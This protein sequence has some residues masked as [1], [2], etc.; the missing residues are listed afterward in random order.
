[1]EETASTISDPIKNHQEHEENRAEEIDPII[2]ESAS[3]VGEIAIKE[4]TV[5]QQ[6]NELTLDQKEMQI[7]TRETNEISQEVD[8]NSLED[9]TQNLSSKTEEN[10]DQIFKYN[11]SIS[12]I[13]LCSATE[14]YEPNA[15]CENFTKGCLWSPD[16]TCLL[17]PA[18]DFRLRVYELPTILYSGKFPQDSLSSLKPVFSIKEGGI[19]YDCS[20]YPLMNSW[21]PETCC[22]ISTSKETPIHLWDAF[23]GQLRATYRAYNQVDEVEAAISVQF[24]DHGQTVWAG[25]KGALRSFDTN[26]PGRQIE[27]IFLKHDF[28]NV[29][30]I[31]SCI[32]ENPKM[33]GL[34]AFGT[35][36]KCIGLYNNGPLCS[37]KASSGVTQVE[38]SPCGTKLYAAVRRNDEFV[39]WDLRNP[40]IILYSLEGRRS[41]TN[42][43]IQFS[44]SPDGN[45]VI[46]GGTNG[47]VNVWKTSEINCS[48]I[49]P[50]WRISL[51]GDC[52]NG[53]NVHKCL[54]IMAT[55]SGQRLCEED[56]VI[57]DNSV[58]LWYCG[59]GID[60]S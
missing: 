24:S 49:Q 42:Q 60:K 58:R 27:D 57:R 38:F 9:D 53:V 48:E 10:E 13:L 50:S 12:P 19:V 8:K 21:Q 2:P 14:E 17:V 26:R 39:C 28:P 55:S 30:G 5:T 29:T 6:M 35:Y 46:S 18:E 15:N 16:G 36:S 41:N 32:R 54:P 37:F 11:W 59:F 52:V 3:M 22:F 33:P 25:F 56:L 1:M 44:S 20:W 31:V 43:R 45:D 34:L 23:T 47:V 7:E 4:S 40:G 51:S